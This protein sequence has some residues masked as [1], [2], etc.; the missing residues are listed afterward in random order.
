[1]QMKVIK[2]FLKITAVI[3]TSLGLA[4][5][6]ARHTTNGRVGLYTYI[7]ETGVVSLPQIMQNSSFI[8]VRQRCHV[9]FLLKFR[10][11]HLACVI[12]VH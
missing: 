10:R 2:T 9:L 11:I 8:E 7:D 4:L 3:V 6:K 1:M 12:D 5:V